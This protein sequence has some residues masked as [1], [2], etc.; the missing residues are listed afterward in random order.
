MSFDPE[1][2]MVIFVLSQQPIQ[3]EQN[4]ANFIQYFFVTKMMLAML[5]FLW[6]S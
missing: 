5:I 3:R 4:E 1:Y 2:C 6:E